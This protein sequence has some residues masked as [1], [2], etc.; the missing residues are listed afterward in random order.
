MKVVD[1]NQDKS[2][3]IIDVEKPICEKDSV[4]IKTHYVALNRADLLQREGNYPAPDGWPKY[5]GLEVSGEVEE[6]GDSVKDLKVGDRVCALLGGGG[7]AE[8]VK[9][10]SE[11]VI[12]VGDMPLDKACCIPEVYSTAY[13]NLFVEGN[14]QKG[15][16]VLVHAGASGV[17]I[18]VTQIAKA[19]GAKVIATVRSDEKAKEIKKFGADIIVNVKSESEEKIFDQN[20]VDIVIDCVGGDMAGK[21]FTKMNR[22]GRWIC[23][24]TLGGDMTQ[25]D[26]RETY[27]KGVRLIGSTLRSRTNQVKHQIL[28]NLQEKIFPMIEN[29][30][31]E[32]VI[33]KVFDFVDVESAHQEMAQNKNIGKILLMI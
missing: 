11:L 24:A 3:S 28:S 31:I 8:Y 5:M 30:E 29:G 23:I 2:L 25:R 17:G 4:I 32:P 7:Y 33:H 6:V 18:A 10:P 12:K 1:I 16:T 20:P 26:L 9:V 15:E 14:L 22:G 21:C 19:F 27:K 13:L